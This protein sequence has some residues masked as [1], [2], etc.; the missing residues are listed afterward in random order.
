VAGLGFAALD[1][2][3]FATVGDLG[4]A[5]LAV[6]R[7]A[8]PDAFT[9]PFRF[10]AVLDFAVAIRNSLSQHATWRQPGVRRCHCAS[11]EKRYAGDPAASSAWWRE[12]SPFHKASRFTAARPS[13][14]TRR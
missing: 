6:L 5:T 3:G 7:F 10:L 4:F 12:Y 1:D 9:L 14:R 13:A 2:L 11:V 8:T